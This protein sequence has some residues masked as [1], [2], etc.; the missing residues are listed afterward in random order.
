VLPSRAPRD[1]TPAAALHRAATLRNGTWLNVPPREQ[2]NQHLSRW[3]FRDGLAVRYGRQIWERPRRCDGCGAAFTERHGGCCPT[4]GLPTRRHNDVQDQFEE[5]FEEAGFA[6][7]QRLPVVQQALREGDVG[8]VGDLAVRGVY[9]AQRVAVFD[10]KVVDLDCP[11]YQ[12]SDPRK[13]IEDIERRT[14]R[15]YAAACHERRVDFAPLVVTCDG[16]LGPAALD[17]VRRIVRALARKSGRRPALIAGAVKARLQL[18]IVRAVSH[19]F[20][21][22]RRRLQTEHAGASLADAGGVVARGAPQEEGDWQ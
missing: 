11:T 18:A 2:D 1:R 9:A 5:L 17:V 22:A 19:T 7:I 4:G 12:R 6:G 21:G 16:A 8:I 3:A 14:R 20:R 10:V 13:V 15:R